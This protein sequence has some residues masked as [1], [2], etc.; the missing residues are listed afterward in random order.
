M[1]QP[2]RVTTSEGD[3]REREEVEGFMG[4]DEWRA[5]KSLSERSVV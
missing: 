1:P 2:N 5:V 4:R 3:D